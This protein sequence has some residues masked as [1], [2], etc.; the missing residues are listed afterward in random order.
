MNWVGREIVGES[1][2]LS[3]PKTCQQI[4]LSQ[5]LMCTY[6][7][8]SVKPAKSKYVARWKVNRLNVMILLF[9]ARKC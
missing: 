3:T 8:L 7:E 4:R 1:L 2:G 5:R 9:A 6:Q